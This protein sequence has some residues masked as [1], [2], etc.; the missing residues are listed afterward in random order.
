MTSKVKHVRELAGRLKTQY[1][2]INGANNSAAIDVIVVQSLN[3]DS[4]K[5]ASPFYVRFGKLDILKPKGQLVTIEVN[6]QPIPEVLMKLDANG[7]A[8]FVNA[9]EFIAG[10]VMAQESLKCFLDTSEFLNV[11][12]Y[13]MEELDP[14]LKRR[15]QSLENLDEMVENVIKKNGSEPGNLVNKRDNKEVENQSVDAS[16]IETLNKARTLDEIKTSRLP[17]KPGL[18]E[19]NYSIRTPKGVRTVKGNIFLWNSNDKVIISDIDGTITKTAFRGQ[20]LSL[21][22]K[23]WYHDNIVDLY[24]SIAN[25]GYKVL[26]LSARP[27]FQSERTRNT[28][29]TI[30]QNEKSLPIGPVLVNPIHFLSAF[31]VEIINKT[32]DEFKISCLNGIRTLFDGLNPFYAGFGDKITDYKTYTALGI[33]DSAIFVVNQLGQVNFNPITKAQLTYETLV[34]NLH[35]YFP[36]KIFPN[37]PL[38]H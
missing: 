9:N 33:P 20:L 2:D 30:K 6:S 32:P 4:L 3:R 24:S 17:L 11:P 35:E 37:L 16:T 12:K 19:I 34:R 1:N 38:I 10:K 15:S 8:Y 27:F 26:Y 13:K 31:H 36:Q 18:N 7:E 21:F 5:R 23:S 22:G 28:L 25:N 29:Q 14:R